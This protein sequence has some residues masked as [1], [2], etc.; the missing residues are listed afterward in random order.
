M[1]TLARALI[2]AVAFLDL[3]DDKAI[4]PELATQ[5]LEEFAFTLTHC[6][7]EEK[8]A[9]TEVLAAMHAAERESGPRPEMLEFLDSFMESFGLADEPDTGE[10]DTPGRL[11]L[12]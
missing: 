6:S 4:D 2:N 12:M 11:N 10:A 8:Q 7:D 5:A 1:K 9:V 3:S